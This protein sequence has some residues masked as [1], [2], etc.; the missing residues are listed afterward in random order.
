MSISLPSSIFD[1]PSVIVND[2]MSSVSPLPSFG[3]AERARVL[4]L[5]DERGWFL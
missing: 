2:F 3:C 5:G 4:E 1:H